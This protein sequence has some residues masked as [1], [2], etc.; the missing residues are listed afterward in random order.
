VIRNGQGL[1]HDPTALPAGNVTIKDSAGALGA[2]Y[3]LP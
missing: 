2:L 3:G 1:P